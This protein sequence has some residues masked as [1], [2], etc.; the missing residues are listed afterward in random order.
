MDA[1]GEDFAVTCTDD[2][3]NKLMEDSTMMACQIMEMF[4]VDMS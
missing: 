2:E 4:L 1:M 3:A